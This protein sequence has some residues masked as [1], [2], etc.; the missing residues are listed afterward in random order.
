MTV[1]F[2][3][4]R[5]SG[6]EG[7]SKVKTRAPC[8]IYNWMALWR[9]EWLM[10]PIRSQSTCDKIEKAIWISTNLGYQWELN[11]WEKLFIIW[12]VLCENV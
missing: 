6:Q 1:Q 11:D 2:W 5:G 4:I 10:Y 9:D 7:S 12:E 8:I 3:M